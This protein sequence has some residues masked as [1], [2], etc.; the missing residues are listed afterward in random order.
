MQFSYA[1][2]LFLTNLEAFC[3]D[4]CTYRQMWSY[5]RPVTWFHHSSL[6]LKPCIVKLCQ[7]WEFQQLIHRKTTKKPVKVVKPNWATSF[8][9]WDNDRLPQQSPKYRLPSSSICRS[10]HMLLL[11]LGNKTSFTPKKSRK[12]LQ[13]KMSN[14]FVINALIET[15]TIDNNMAAISKI[16]WFSVQFCM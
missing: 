6:N 15:S 9:N 14:L 2:C 13:R 16:G 11:L 7:S 3:R 10:L 12:A 1:L 4:C 5:T 8:M